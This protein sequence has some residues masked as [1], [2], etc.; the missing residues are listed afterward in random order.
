MGQSPWTSADGSTSSCL[1]SKQETQRSKMWNFDY[2]AAA[3][4]FTGNRPFG[5]Q[6]HDF[7]PNAALWSQHRSGARFQN[8]ASGAETRSVESVQQCHKT[9]QKLSWDSGFTAWGVGGQV[10]VLPLWRLFYQGLSGLIYGVNSNDRNKF[11]DAEEELNG[12]VKDELPVAGVLALAKTLTPSIATR[13][14]QKLSA[15]RA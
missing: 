4:I 3:N 15:V 13:S 1:H 10:E 11:V 2:P 9:R 8:S 14:G 7:A 12:L 6:R 5:T